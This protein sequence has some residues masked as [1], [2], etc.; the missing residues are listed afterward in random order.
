MFY[1]PSRVL[2]SRPEILQVV[3]HIAFSDIKSKDAL[4]ARLLALSIETQA[5]LNAWSQAM[6]KLT[7]HTKLSCCILIECAAIEP[8]LAGATVALS[9]FGLVGK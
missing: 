4:L 1:S 2:E 6:L 5:P 3:N 9:S 7:S 8:R